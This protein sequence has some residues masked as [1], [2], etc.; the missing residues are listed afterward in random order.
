MKDFSPFL[1]SSFIVSN[2]G[3]SYA[4][5]SRSNPVS[6]TFLFFLLCISP[7]IWISNQHL[8]NI[9]LLGFVSFTQKW[10][11]RVENIVGWIP[12][13]LKY[14]NLLTQVNFTQ[15]HFEHKTEQIYL[16]MSSHLE[17]HAKRLFH[18]FPFK[19][20][21]KIIRYMLCHFHNHRVVKAIQ[22]IIYAET[23][24]E[25]W[26]QTPFPIWFLRRYDRKSSNGN[27][28]YISDSFL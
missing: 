8:Q 5:S 2:V 19:K 26:K 12:N 14:N 24:R 4:T 6:W 1:Q 28:V 17:K 13:V 15:R 18:L 16:K 20:I 3:P 27:E 11:H 7:F 9:F 22:Y 23:M 25:K 21:S 10:N